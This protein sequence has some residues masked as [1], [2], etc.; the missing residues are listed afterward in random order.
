MPIASPRRSSAPDKKPAGSASRAGRRR[1][2]RG[3]QARPGAAGAAR[4][5]ASS[6]LAVASASAR[7]PRRQRCA[8]AAIGSGVSGGTT[9]S[10]RKRGRS[11]PGTPSR[12][13]SARASSASPSSA[14]SCAR[15]PRRRRARRNH[16]RGS[17]QQPQCAKSRVP[18]RF[19][20]ILAAADALQACAP[21][22]RV[23]TT[24]R[25]PT[26]QTTSTGRPRAPRGDRR[27]RPAHR[28]H[29]GRRVP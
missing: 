19:N 27:L 29:G 7:L 18:P 4:A 21:W 2:P 10:A 8:S 25:N 15:A 22:A 23:T 6:R 12:S 3:L 14:M 9:A 16:G 20:I 28:R 13:H 1:Q 17:P 5:C 11:A 26:A 24:V